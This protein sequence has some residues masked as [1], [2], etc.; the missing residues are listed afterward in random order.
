[1]ACYTEV[2]ALVLPSESQI[3][4]HANNDG[5]HN[6]HYLILDVILQI[7]QRGP[8]NLGLV[9]AYPPHNE[10]Q[11]VEVQAVDVCVNDSFAHSHRSLEY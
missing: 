6:S 2:Q 9:T 1:M 4:R 7:L 8:I 3:F 5:G 10:V 11:A